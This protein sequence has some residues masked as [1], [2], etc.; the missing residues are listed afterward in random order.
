MQ[1]HATVAVP[2]FWQREGAAV[3]ANWV[4]V[5]VVVEG[6]D[7]RRVALEGIA[8]I[9]IYRHIVSCHLPVER[10]A[11]VVPRRNVGLVAIEVGLV[12]YSVVFVWRITELPL[13][14]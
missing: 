13:T 6:G 10:H 4:L 3:R 14:V 2:S 9:I 8:H 12:G 1:Q 5:E 11:D 7:V